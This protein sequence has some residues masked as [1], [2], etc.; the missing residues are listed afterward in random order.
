MSRQQ[1]PSLALVTL[2]VAGCG[3]GG[4]N[5]WL[6]PEPH[7]PETEEAVFVAYESHQLLAIDGEDTSVK[8][9]GGPRAPQAY[10]RPDVLCRLHI[11]A[12][13]HSVVFHPTANSRERRTLTFTA[14][15]GK[16]YGLDRSGC[17][18]SLNRLQDACR[19]EIREVKNQ[20]EGG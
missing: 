13:E 14:L 17:T 20:A 12:G 4:L 9:W 8:C 16:S 10:S 15:P 6:Y 19:V 18:A 2:V 5:Y 3:T 11:R 1:L 7:L